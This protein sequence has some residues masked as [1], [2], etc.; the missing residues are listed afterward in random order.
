MTAVELAKT[1]DMPREQWLEL[2]RRGIDGS[3]ASVIL[4]LNPWKTQ[5]D[6][7]LEKTGEFTED[8]D[9][10]KMYWGRILED[11]V[12]QEFSKGGCYNVTITD[13]YSDY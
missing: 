3:D 8:E 2:R 7:W 13:K 9:N 11:I 4:G 1:L 5:M 12:A 10:E 6:L